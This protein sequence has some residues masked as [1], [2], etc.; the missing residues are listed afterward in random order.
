MNDENEYEY[1]SVFRNPSNYGQSILMGEYFVT[2]AALGSQIAGGEGAIVGAGI[3][4]IP[5][6]IHGM[7]DR[8]HGKG[9]GTAQARAIIE[10]L[11]GEDDA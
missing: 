6:Y 7:I 11:E 3:A 2:G 4:S 8:T 9:L 5:G 1:E 10:M